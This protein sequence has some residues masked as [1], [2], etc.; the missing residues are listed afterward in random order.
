MR[1]GMNRLISLL[2]STTIF[3]SML[4]IPASA[5]DSSETSTTYH[6]AFETVGAL[7]YDED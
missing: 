3:A 2:C 1:K 7:E 4:L 6:N 5:A